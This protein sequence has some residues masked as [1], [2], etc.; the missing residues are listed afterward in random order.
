MDIVI[1]SLPNMLLYARSKDVNED[2]L[3]PELKITDGKVSMS[4]LVNTDGAVVSK[5]PVLS[6]WP[7]FLAIADLPPRNRK[8]FENIK[9]GSLF[10]G[11]GHPDFD[12][13]FA[14]I[15]KNCL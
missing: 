8:A 7:L 15:K 4:L 1:K 9:L 2:I 11:S 12:C 14:H 6:A 10:V 13:I 3:L 5:S